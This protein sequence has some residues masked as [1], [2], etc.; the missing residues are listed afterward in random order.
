MDKE[1]IEDIR[2]GLITVEEELETAKNE[3]DYQIEQIHHLINELEEELDDT[4]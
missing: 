2:V 3:I 4:E 1:R